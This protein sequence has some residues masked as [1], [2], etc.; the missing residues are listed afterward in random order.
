MIMCPVQY[1]TGALVYLRRNAALVIIAHPGASEGG[2]RNLLLS[3][4]SIDGTGGE[5]TDL[6]TQERNRKVN[7]S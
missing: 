2:V 4:P 7:A 5:T 6:V 3:D 1:N